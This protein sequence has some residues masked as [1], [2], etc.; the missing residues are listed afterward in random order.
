MPQLFR[1]TKSHL[2]SMKTVQPEKDP[3][4]LK[5]LQPDKDPLGLKTLQP[6]KDPLGLT[7]DC[8]GDQAYEDLQ[9]AVKRRRASGE[10]A[11]VPPKKPKQEQGYRSVSCNESFV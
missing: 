7:R 9:A 8:T 1:P 10:S 6:E 3:L 5:G 11:T 2:A 4:G